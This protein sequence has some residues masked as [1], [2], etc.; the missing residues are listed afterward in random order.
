LLRRNKLIHEDTFSHPYAIVVK[1]TTALKEYHH[2][3][4][5]PKVE[6]APVG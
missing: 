1:A 5:K 6:E 3:Q 2:A 4:M